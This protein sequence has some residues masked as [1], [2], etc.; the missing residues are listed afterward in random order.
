MVLKNRI[1]EKALS[2]PEANCC[3]YSKGYIQ[4]EC[5]I[6]LTCLLETKKS[7]FLCLGCSIKCHDEHEIVPIGFKRSIRCDCGNNN[8][9]IDYKLKKKMKLIMIIHIIII[10]IIW[11]INIVI[12]ILKMM[13]IPPW[14][15]FSS[16]K[17][18]SIRS[19]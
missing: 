1:L 16:V 13:A 10:I 3:A 8:F 17:I 18:G 5:F 6:C 4:Q 9:F 15:N 11:K 14:L 12:A 7:A 2:S 19:F